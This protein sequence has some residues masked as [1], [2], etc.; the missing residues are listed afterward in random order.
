MFLN[1]TLNFHNTIVHHTSLVLKS[2]EEGVNE[3]CWC[4]IT[5]VQ[6]FE[7]SHIGRMQQCIL[8]GDGDSCSNQ[9]IWVN[10][11]AN[12]GPFQIAAQKGKLIPCIEF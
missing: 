6:V 12:K 10:D 1:Q 9:H 7:P 3:M 4:F 11:Q 8:I 2:W 5:D